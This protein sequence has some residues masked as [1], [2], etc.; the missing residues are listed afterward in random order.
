MRSLRS[1]PWR[2]YC[3][4]SNELTICHQKQPD[5]DSFSSQTSESSQRAT[6]FDDV[7]DTRD[8]INCH[9]AYW[10]PTDVCVKR[11]LPKRQ[12]NHVICYD[13][14]R[15]VDD[16]RGCELIKAG[17]SRREN[18]KKRRC[19]EGVNGLRESRIVGAAFRVDLYGDLCSVRF[20]EI[21]KKSRRSY[22]PCV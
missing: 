3:W 5:L 8:F 17:R 15:V 9:C 13:P 4:K 12:R 2:C 18:G 11:Q 21:K 20:V 7:L 19:F 10:D 6:K 22:P 16:L 1:R 14:S